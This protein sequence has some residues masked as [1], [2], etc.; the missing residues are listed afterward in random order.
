M[1]S[2]F[3]LFNQIEPLSVELTDYLETTLKRKEVGKRSTLLDEGQTAKYIYFIEQGLVRGYYHFKNKEYTSWLMKEGDI[4]LSVQSF[5]FQEPSEEIIET[6]EDAVI[7]YITYDQLQFA[8]SKFP[9]FNYHRAVILENYYAQ[10]EKRHKMRTKPALD[11][12]KYLMDNH[13]D[14]MGRVSDKHLASYLGV[15]TGT[16]SY[17]KGR[18]AKGITTS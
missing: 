6:L 17:E 18:F 14:L 3:K 9:E 12:Y 7:H 16:F 13:A 11:R 4:F 1:E 10:S 8:Y 2:L 5:F 15:T